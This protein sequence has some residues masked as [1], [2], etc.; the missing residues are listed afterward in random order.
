MTELVSGLPPQSSAK[1][2]DIVNHN[3]PAEGNEITSE[4]VEIAKKRGWLSCHYYNG[5]QPTVSRRF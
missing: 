4:Q 1:E 2:F 5:W 3:S